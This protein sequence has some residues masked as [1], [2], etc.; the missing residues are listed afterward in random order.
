MKTTVYRNSSAKSVFQH[1]FLAFVLS[2][3]LCL[4]ACGSDMDLQVENNSLSEM[5]QQDILGRLRSFNQT[6]ISMPQSRLCVLGL[7]SVVLADGKGAYDG[8]KVGGQI[9]AIFG[10][11]GATTGAVVGGVIVGGAASYAQYKMANDIGN[12]S[13]YSLPGGPVIP[14]EVV[15]AGYV[16]SKDE[17]LPSD[18][19]QGLSYGLDT[20]S[21]VIGIQHN[22]VL[23]KLDDAEFDTIKH[24]FLEKLDGIEREIVSTADFEIE[25][26]RIVSNP[27]ADRY[28]LSLVSDYVMQL[29]V[30]AVSNSCQSRDDLDEIISF[31]T[32]EVKASEEL[33]AEEKEWL[34][35][36]FA[37]MGY[38][39]DY[40][41]NKW[42]YEE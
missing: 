35:A 34:Y 13:P 39:F 9:G 12:F 30:D 15:E 3:S 18:Y 36:G 40:W 25:Y 26:D 24:Q 41:S 21:V 16:I 38:S 5:S 19:A 11:Q 33:L 2:V 27:L 29:F 6:K 10:P 17:I 28:D 31:Y 42:S 7:L 4:I 8:A 32:S 37:V 14:H 20:C 22:K 23:D 1:T